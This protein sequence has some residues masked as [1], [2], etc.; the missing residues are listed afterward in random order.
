MHRGRHRHRSAAR[1]APHDRSSPGRQRRRHQAFPEAGRAGAI[2]GTMGRA[3]P[4]LVEGHHGALGQRAGEP[5][6]SRRLAS[7]R[8]HPRGARHRLAR[9]QQL[10][11]LSPAGR[12]RDRHD[13]QELGSDL[14]QQPLRR[15]E[16]RI[17]LEDAIHANTLAAPIGSASTTRQADPEPASSPISSCWSEICSKFP[18]RISTRPRC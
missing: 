5:H 9:R 15:R 6:L 3:R 17:T 10:Q 7:A 13:R 18:R 11:H 16:E 8:G 4:I 14:Q 2:I 1:P 12:D